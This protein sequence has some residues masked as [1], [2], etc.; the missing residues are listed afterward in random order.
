MAILIAVIVA[1]LSLH[2]LTSGNRCQLPR[3]NLRLGETD[4]AEV[5]VHG[6]TVYSENGSDASAMYRA[7]LFSYWALILCEWVGSVGLAA[8][9]YALLAI[10][11]IDVRG[12]NGQFV[13]VVRDGARSA[14]FRRI[15]KIGSPDAPI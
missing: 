15:A 1:G 10:D 4:S 5:S 2:L 13:A 7:A 8:L 6:Y 9:V 12:L 3:T 14:R 11:R